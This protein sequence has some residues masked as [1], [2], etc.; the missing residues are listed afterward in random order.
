M[1]IVDQSVECKL[2]QET[3]VLGENLT[4]WHFVRQKSHMTRPGF[5]P[6][7]P[8]CAPFQYIH[9]STYIKPLSFPLNSSYFIIP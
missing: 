8:R 1:M 4:Q 5:E 3:G 6:W 7:S 2:A 9:E